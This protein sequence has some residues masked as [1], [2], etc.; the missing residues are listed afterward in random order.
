MPKIVDYDSKR[1]EVAEAT[2]RVI[3]KRGIDN[4]T[5]REIA[6]EAQCS[7]GVITHY[8]RDKKELLLYAL[9]LAR[10]RLARR[11]ER[12]MVGA[13]D[14]ETIRGVVFES[15]PLDTEGRLGMQIWLSFWGRAVSDPSML[16]EQK[17]RYSE[18]RRFMTDLLLEAQRNGVIR[19]DID[20][21]AEADSITAMGDGVGIQ[22]TLEPSRFPPERQMAI[23][24][25]YLS[26]L[27]QQQPPHT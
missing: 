1:E 18:S 9:R 6:K 21:L 27:F 17:L 8:Y 22:A 19:P 13:V 25:K 5:I 16:E 15:L 10:V 14:R 26:T 2:W 20:A 7:T 4:T 11:V 23:M 3:A 24:D 12:K